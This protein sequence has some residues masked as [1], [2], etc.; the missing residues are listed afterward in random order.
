MSRHG[1][2]PERLFYGEVVGTARLLA[3]EQGS[4][5][6]AV[7]RIQGLAGGRN[8]LLTEA[9]GIGVGAWS[10]DP[11]H[12]VDLLTVDLLAVSVHRLDLDVLRHWIVIGQQ[13]GLSGYRYRA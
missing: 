10:V 5:A 13:R 3:A 9:T 7:T 11:G 4:I 12:P 8:D 6:D 1:P 2:D